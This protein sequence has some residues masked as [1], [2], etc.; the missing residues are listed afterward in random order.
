VQVVP[1]YPAMKAEVDL[2]RLQ[3]LTPECS[4]EH[5][6]KPAVGPYPY[7]ITRRCMHKF[8]DWPPGAVTASGTALCQLVQ[9]C[10]YFVSQSSEFC[11]HNPLKRTAT[12]NTKGKRIFRY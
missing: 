1:K 8:P 12:S 2:H 10:H 11:F 3:T 5:S 4:S 9:L 7:T 6:Q